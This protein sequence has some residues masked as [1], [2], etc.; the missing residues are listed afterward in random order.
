MV[1][2]EASWCKIDQVSRTKIVGNSWQVS[3][4]NVYFTLKITR[5][6][7]LKL[8]VEEQPINKNRNGKN[9]ETVSNNKEMENAFC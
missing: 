8:H 7:I 9:K 5:R 2:K 4:C 1:S 6:Y 3:L